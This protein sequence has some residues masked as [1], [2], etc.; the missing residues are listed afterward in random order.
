M[1]GMT[2][3]AFRNK[4]AVLLV[5]VLVL[6]MGILSYFTLPMEF[7]PSAD[8][9]QVSVVV[10][11]QGTGSD[12]MA[13]T[14]TGP[15]EQA[16]AG[17]KGKTEIF[18]TTGDGF[19]KIDIN[20]TP[21][22][23]M[24][25]GKADVQEA[26]AAL[27][28]PAN[29]SKPFVV[30]LN[31]SMIPIADIS[32][33][34]E[35]GLT[36]ENMELASREFLPKL[37]SVKGVASVGFYGVTEQQVSVRVDN[38]KLAESQI[39]FQAVMGALQGQN[40]SAA[41]GEKSIDGK[42]SNIKVVGTV[43]GLE[44]LKSLPIVPGVKLSDVAVVEM[45]SMEGNLT[46]V[47]GK[48]VLI[49]IITKDAN[50]N[51]V[52]I[53][54]DVEDKIAQMNEDHPNAEVE[55]FFATTDMVENSVNSM[56]KEVLLGALFA[57]IVIVLFLRNIRTT[58]ITIVSIPLS[59]CLT[60]FL[61]SLSGVTLN[62]LTLGGVAVAVGR[63]VD[64]SIVVIEN[65]FRK[66]QKLEFS[67]ELIIE[68]TKEMAS[69]ITSSTLVT[70]AV[71]LPIA[72]LGTGLEEFL[73]PFALTIT[74]SLLA[75][76]VI[77][78]T[79]VP[80]MSAGL[81]KNA[82]LPEHKTPKRFVSFVGWALNHKWVILLT[83]TVLLIGSVMTYVNLP[84]GVIDSS[85]SDF[86][87]VNLEY[88]NE[89]P[90]E[91]IEEKALELE[92]FLL[93][94]EQPEYI[95][96]QM[97]NSAEMAQYG[98]V[99]SPTTVT[100][101]AMMK[102]DADAQKFIDAVNGE[103]ENY[104][105][106]TLSAGAGSLLG[107]SS[108]SVFI[109]VIGN[110]REALQVAADRV[111]DAIK[112][113]EYVEKVTTNED[114]KKSVYSIHVDPEKANPGKLAGQLGAMLNRMPIGSVQLDGKNAAVYLEPLVDP[115]TGGDIENIMVMGSTGPVKISDIAELVK[116]EKSTA[117]L[118]KGGK[119]YIRVT[120]AVDP[121][122]LSIVAADIKEAVL[123]TPDAKGVDLP[124]GVDAFVGGASAQQADDFA[125]LGMIMLASIG[126]VYLIM[127]ITFKTL[128]VPL[129]ILFTLPFAA[130]GA[131][132]GLLVTGI[133][134]D[135]TALLGGLMLIGIVVTNAI[136]LLDRVKHNEEFMTIREALLEAAGTRMRPIFMTALATIC[137]MLPL[138]FKSAETGSLVSQSLAVVVIGG[139]AVATLLTLIVIP[140]IYELL[141]FRKSSKQRKQ[142]SAASSAHIEA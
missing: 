5:S 78:M 29:V 48:D 92:A 37:Q 7:M 101:M 126:L 6:V 119:P 142:S 16:V 28:L 17:V 31:T 105:G 47:N 40:T 140:V 8:N 138:L 41:V 72:V 73:L 52:A 61:L 38:S 21:G 18:S 58:F 136:V 70:V 89:T 34:F 107:G 50:S 111:R 68:S 125:E 10:L 82:K 103:K 27:T 90:I 15:I 62:I 129:V 130:I 79:V 24:K 14:V 74:Y 69:A 122:Q 120:A 49:A 112:D 86:I 3:W 12:T 2:K 104:K 75:S 91:E 117:L 84:K 109:D 77:A 33:G 45:A 95:S 98:Q 4:A 116:E 63:L 32:I 71:F 60:L 46:R 11:G 93:K 35:D 53:M 30:Q 64:D 96:V 121:K 56:M 108:T 124:D 139:L 22:S 137:A 133:T 134:P 39:P 80:L 81:L 42:T 55:I 36:E 26:L 100:I 9:P 13:E 114:A 141:H 23:D 88:P 94:Q 1:T 123:G 83:C 59:L 106:A 127:V 128:R 87:A 110:D 115:K 113:I 65:I 85:D 43:E 67:K 132:L 118:H 131:V 135:L 102:E 51:A 25:Q 20:F 19:S 57:T 54:G 97:G 44:Q 99:G 76:L 66:M